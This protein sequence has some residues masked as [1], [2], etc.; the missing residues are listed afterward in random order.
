MTENKIN[1]SSGETNDTNSGVSRGMLFGAGFTLSGCSPAF[2]YHAARRHLITAVLFFI[3][4]GL[5]LAGV[6]TGRVVYKMQPARRAVDT[7]FN[8][9]IFPAITIAN[10]EA[11]VHGP[12]PFAVVP[13]IAVHY[14]LDRVAM[15]FFGLFTLLLLLGWSVSLVAAAAERQAG[16]F[17]RGERPLRA[18]RTLIGIPLLVVLALDAIYEWPNGAAIVWLT[19]VVTF[20]ILFT[21]ELL[22]AQTAIPTMKPG[23]V[24]S[25]E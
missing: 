11:V 5:I 12:E 24:A 6:E 16:D 8:E 18:W 23:A 1:Q 21:L 13:A 3:L 19:A 25:Q 15:D 10:G 20:L 4:F 7:A 14:L 17:L 22:T 2:C 9:G